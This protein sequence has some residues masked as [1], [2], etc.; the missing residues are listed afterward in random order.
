MASPPRKS[1]P[2]PVPPELET[3]G[4]QAEFL[5]RYDADAYVR[6]S[7]TVDIVLFTVVEGA[8]R[9]LLIRRK[10]HPFKDAWALPGGFIHA[11]ES[12]EDAARRELAE[13]AGISDIFLEQLYTF[14]NPGR[15]PR[16]WVISVA[17][18]ALVASERLHLRAGTDAS[19]VDWFL[20]KDGRSGVEVHRVGGGGPVELAFDHA[21]ILA[22]AVKR[23]RGKLDYVP[24]GFQLLPERFTLSELQTV[25]EAVLGKPLDKRNFRA[26]VQRDGLVKATKEKRGGAHRPAQLFRYV[27]NKRE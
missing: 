8:L 10:K 26:K 16:T 5:Q 3:G 15:D 6:P 17:Y 18:Y 1:R 13:E 25:H 24:I 27:D 23:I 11:D 20:L 12:A 14:S 4:T 7:V 22:T 21:E 2:E 19:D 9:V